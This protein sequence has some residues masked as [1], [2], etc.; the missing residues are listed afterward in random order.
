MGNTIDAERII[1]ILPDGIQTT[2]K[3]LSSDVAL[4]LKKND[5]E[6]VAQLAMKDFHDLCVDLAENGEIE[7]EDDNHTKVAFRISIMST[8]KNK[9]TEGFFF[10]TCNLVCAAILYLA[11]LLRCENIISVALDKVVCSI[12]GIAKSSYIEYFFKNVVKNA[13][14]NP[15]Q[16]LKTGL[17]AS[18]AASVVRAGS[19][20]LKGASSTARTALH[21]GLITEGAILLFMVGYDVWRYLNGEID[22]KKLIQKIVKKVSA[23]AGSVGMSVAGMF[24]GTL[25][26]P[27]IGSFLGGF[28]GSII[29]HMIGGYIGNQITN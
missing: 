19:G 8:I 13:A 6:E 7:E 26:F 22:F 11:R 28:I 29:G 21:T 12:G 1:Q 20:A 25:I 17:R 3:R 9:F 23:A 5:L 14:K 10:E 16:I 15:L 2:I 27:G 4:I 24:I 18:A